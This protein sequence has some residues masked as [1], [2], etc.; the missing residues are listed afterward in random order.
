MGDSMT[1]TDLFRE[2]MRA[3]LAR[4]RQP[5]LVIQFAGSDE[6]ELDLAFREGEKVGRLAKAF[7]KVRWFAFG[8]AVGA[9]LMLLG[10]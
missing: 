5:G 7:D 1:D 8:M 4:P 6:R 2:A 9:V 3:E 10:K